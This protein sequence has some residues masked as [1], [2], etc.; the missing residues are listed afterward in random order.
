MKKYKTA[1]GLIRIYCFSLVKFQPS[2]VN[3]WQESLQV[4]YRGGQKY[5]DKSLN[6]LHYHVGHIEQLV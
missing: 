6:L 2:F 5:L 3:T 4:N 1:L